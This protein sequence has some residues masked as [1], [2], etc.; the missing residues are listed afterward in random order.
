MPGAGHLNIHNNMPAYS[1]Y[2]ARVCGPGSAATSKYEIMNC[3]NDAEG[4][5]FLRQ[6][7]DTVVLDSATASLL[8]S[9]TNMYSV[10]GSDS[11]CVMYMGGAPVG[12]ASHNSDI[13]INDRTRSTV[14]MVYSYGAAFNTVEAHNCRVFPLDTYPD[15]NVEGFLTVHQPTNVTNQSGLSVTSI[16]SNN[17]AGQLDIISGFDYGLYVFPTAEVDDR[18]LI[19]FTL[20]R[21]VGGTPAANSTTI[22]GYDRTTTGFRLNVGADPG[23]T[24][25]LTFGWQ[26]IRTFGDPEIDVFLPSI[27]STETNVA[28]SG[29]VFGAAIS[30]IPAGR[31][32]L[33]FNELATDEVILDCGLQAS[34]TGWALKLKR[35][36]GYAHRFGSSDGDATFTRTTF[37][38]RSATVF[39]WP[40]SF[41][42]SIQ[43]P[44]THNIAIGQAPYKGTLRIWCDTHF[45]ETAYSL[46]Q[47]SPVHIGESVSG[48]GTLTRLTVRD[49]KEDRNY[50][51]VMSSEPDVGPLGRLE[52]AFIGDGM[53]VGYGSTSDDGGFATQIT[54]ARFPTLYFWQLCNPD[55]AT[56]IDQPFQNGILHEFWRPWGQFK[57]L[58]SACVLAGQEDILHGGSGYVGYTATDVWAALLEILEDHSA[59]ADWHPPTTATHGWCGFYTHQHTPWT[60]PYPTCVIN[61]VSFNV[62]WGGDA[63]STV[64]NLASAIN[65]S[66]PTNTLVNCNA[67]FDA[68]SND[69]YMAVNSV[70]AGTAGNGITVATNGLDGFAVFTGYPPNV[71]TFGAVDTLVNVG[72][73]DFVGNFDTDADTTVNN[74]IALINADGPTMALVTPSLVDHSLRITANAGGRVGNSIKATT[75]R[76]GDAYWGPEFYYWPSEALL[77]GSD[78][79]VGR[80]SNIVLCT[81]PPIG[82]SPDYTSGKETERQDLNTSIRAYSGAGVTIADVDA[83][84]KDPGTPTQLLPL[85]FYGTAAHSP[86]KIS[87]DGHMALFTLL[88]PLMPGVGTAPS[89][90]SYA[91]NPATYASGGPIS[92]NS[93]TVTGTV[94]RWTVS[95]PLPAG[96]SI[97]STTGDITGTPTTPT[98]AADYNVGAS[99]DAG[100]IVLAVNITIT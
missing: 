69:W 24:V 95:P 91:T 99:N 17:L 98:S 66:S 55:M 19:N 42:F 84:L 28:V 10:V 64:N 78:G 33:G 51:L 74:V 23:S 15:C 76:I 41:L 54:E 25:R 11:P 1:Q 61:G 9:R 3:D 21:V 88:A 37:D 7:A 32:V 18:Y 44:G 60:T 82:D 94:V 50:R 43:Q 27:P 75:N 92:T 73:T 80:A 89:S 12:G 58:T 14:G 31:N 36:S 87:S 4:W 100:T 40:P 20:L 79:L 97:S 8:Y 67:A 71:G 53:T 29:E 30:I 22:L 35:G 93:P 70:A 48:T 85:Y 38:G 96:L 13:F 47:A 81:V 57:T 6:I 45:Q 59:S 52:G 77:G 26:M 83:L 86:I 39:S 5:N 68:N 16:K 34:N 72:G 63:Y 56:V 90:L 49:Y 2:A 46:V 62:V 65:A